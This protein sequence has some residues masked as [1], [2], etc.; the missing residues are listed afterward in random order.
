MEGGGQPSQLR[1]KIRPHKK[2]RNFQLVF[3]VEKSTLLNGLFVEKAFLWHYTMMMRG[4]DPS[5]PTYCL[6]VS[7]KITLRKWW[8]DSSSANWNFFHPMRAATRGGEE[9]F[10]VAGN[11]VFMRRTQIEAHQVLKEIILGSGFSEGSAVCLFEYCGMCVDCRVSSPAAMVPPVKGFANTKKALCL[12]A[13]CWVERRFFSFSGTMMMRRDPT[14]TLLLLLLWPCS[15]EGRRGR[16]AIT[17]LTAPGEKEEE[18]GSFPPRDKRWESVHQ[19]VALAAELPPTRPHTESQKIEWFGAKPA[20]KCFLCWHFEQFLK[21]ALYFPKQETCF[22]VKFAVI[23]FAPVVG[24][25]EPPSLRYLRN[26]TNSGLLR[27][28]KKRKFISAAK[29]KFPES[30]HSLFPPIF[31]HL[32]L[33]T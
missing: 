22:P 13:F 9:F 26:C 7:I 20:K 17:L 29:R 1:Q 27:G 3:K 18:E 24:I 28:R 5:P 15:K 14:R 23:S 21:S 6:F 31:Q 16:R 30:T 12:I 8:Q 11:D 10:L 2:R 32:Y 33:R 4:E 25:W 19:K